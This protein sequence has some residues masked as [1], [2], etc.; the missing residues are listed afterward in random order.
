MIQLQW[1]VYSFFLDSFEAYFHFQG[2]IDINNNLKSSTDTPNYTFRHL[3]SRE[4]T[5]FEWIGL[6]SVPVFV[7]LALLNEIILRKLKLA[8]G[9]RLFSSTHHGQELYSM[10]R[11]GEILL[12]RLEND[13]S[14]DSNQF[15]QGPN[16]TKCVF[17]TR[18]TL[19]S[20]RF[21]NSPRE[22]IDNAHEALKSNAYRK[23]NIRSLYNIIWLNHAIM[24]AHMFRG[25]A[26]MVNIQENIIKTIVNQLEENNL[27]QFHDYMEKWDITNHKDVRDRTYNN[28]E[29]LQDLQ[30]DYLK[31]T[32][33]L[34]LRQRCLGPNNIQWSSDDENLQRHIKH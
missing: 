26:I 4:N 12:E 9:R 18:K 6:N 32:E 33:K 16:S 3:I 25:D 17:L 23:D 22:I 15:I 13:A 1:K 28:A 19:F 10:I 20:V 11:Y 27:T 29:N 31:K 2:K 7:R 5:I 21:A 8:T 14:V 30:K 34:T 24:R